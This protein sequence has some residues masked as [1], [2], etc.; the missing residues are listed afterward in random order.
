VASSPCGTGGLAVPWW[1]HVPKLM[2][3]VAS[4]WQGQGR[5]IFCLAVTF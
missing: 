2:H 3:V 4:G 1:T 5:V